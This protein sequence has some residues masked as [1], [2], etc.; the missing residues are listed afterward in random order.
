MS[1]E[2]LIGVAVIL[3]VG[4][5]LY[6]MVSKK[7]TV[8][9]AVKETLAD[10]KASLLAGLKILEMRVNKMTMKDIKQGVRW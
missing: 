8:Q 5:V 4:Y 9:E 6:K 2:T 7:E 3:G 1:I 10:A